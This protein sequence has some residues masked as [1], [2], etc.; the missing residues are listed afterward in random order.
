MA[1]LGRIALNRLFLNG[2]KNLYNNLNPLRNFRRNQVN[3]FL[4]RCTST[5]T[6]PRDDDY[7]SI[8]KNTERVKGE[9]S[10]HEFQAE[11]RMLLDIVARS[12]YSDKEVF[13][14]ELISNA[15]DALEKFRFITLSDDD[16]LKGQLRD[17]NRALEIHISTDKQSRTLTI[18]DT[19]IGMSKDDLI[20]NLGVIARSGSKAFLEQ[21]KSKDLTSDSSSNIIGQFGVGFYSVF[22]VADKVDVFTRSSTEDQGY[23]WSSDGTGS[24]EIHEAEGVEC[25]TKIVLHLKTD[26][27]EFCDD[28]TVENVINKYSNFIGSPIYLNGKKANIVKPVWL[29]D[30]KTVTVQQHNEFY[31]F[32]SGSY[33]VP[34]YILHYNTD[35]PLSIHALLYFPEGKPGLFEMSREVESGVALYTR[36]VLIKNKTDNILPKWLRFVK[37]VVD[38]EDIPLNL[39]RELLQ[40]SALIRK[41]RDV[42]SSKVV[43]FLQDQLKKK[44]EEY[45]KFYN[46]YGLFIKEGIITNPIQSEKEDAGKLLLFESSHK[47]QGEK[48]TLDNYIERAKDSKTIFYLAA[49]SRSLAEA[50]PYYESLKSKQQEVLFCYE[51]YDELVL[52]QLQQFKGYKLVSVE[53][54]MRDD[55]AANDLSNLGTYCSR[56]K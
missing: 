13:V 51:P 38:S 15:S 54:D 3:V 39:S 52:M 17:T 34:R 1:N 35:V 22:M 10:K 31:R 2:R 4:V 14:R 55:K 8:I 45:E 29:S 32:I 47:N 33:D 43:K 41:L 9:P 28:S 53:K 56:N 42:L 50:S 12:L 24:Y 26:C 37:G 16:N 6:A 40:N 27:R 21:L 5:D 48:M 46:D 30:P 19:G 44:P 18:Q 20:A 25:G 11:T 23:K 36:K 49:P 7:H